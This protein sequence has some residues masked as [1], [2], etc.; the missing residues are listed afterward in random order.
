MYFLS[1]LLLKTKF[2]LFQ[3]DVSHNDTVEDDFDDVIDDVI[4]GENADHYDDD[5]QQ[6]G[7]DSELLNQ[8]LDQLEDSNQNVP[9]SDQTRTL[10]AARKRPVSSQNDKLSE[11]P[12][13]SSCPMI[14][15]V[16]ILNACFSTVTCKVLLNRP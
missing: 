2:H 15:M 16:Y 9:E 7:S 14:K 10:R 1:P 5:F 3:N 12:G 6:N 4:D 8:D 11:N 13:L